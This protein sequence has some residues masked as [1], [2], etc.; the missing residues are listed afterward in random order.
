M[1]TNQKGQKKEREYRKY[2]ESQGYIIIFK[3]QR[4]RFGKVDFAHLFDTC[5]VRGKEWIF[6]SNK[7]FG[8]S[9]NYLPHQLEI[10]K[11]KIEH[12]LECMKFY[13]VNWKSARW[14]GAGKNKK[15]VKGEF[16]TKLI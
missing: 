9:N 10:E 2:L 6:V 3:S 1:D 12:G 5:A 13:L 11:F 14:E 7:H 15:F 16:I 4:V 8:K